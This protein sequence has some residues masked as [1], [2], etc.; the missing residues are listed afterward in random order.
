MLKKITVTVDGKEYKLKSEDDSLVLESA[1]IVNEQMDML[2]IKS[3]DDLPA[4]TLPVLAAL[5]I[6]GRE[7]ELKK[8]RD[9]EIDF[10]INELSE[11]ANYL[12]S[13]MA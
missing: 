12:E 9:N 11:M 10:L 7:L 2:R 8:I 6:A 13:V 5:N 3:R 1:K 4:T